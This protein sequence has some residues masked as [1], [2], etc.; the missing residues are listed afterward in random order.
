MDRDLGCV[1]RL[2]EAISLERQYLELSDKAVLQ[3]LDKVRKELY[4]EVTRGQEA[5]DYDNGASRYP[6]RTGTGHG[7]EV[8]LRL[9]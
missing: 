8:L 5:G 6:D 3:A 2:R 9:E 1:R 7:S 4:L